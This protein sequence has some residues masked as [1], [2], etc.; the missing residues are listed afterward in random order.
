M[1]EAAEGFGWKELRY[2][3]KLPVLALWGLSEV[4]ISHS[5][6]LLPCN[7]QPLSHVNQHCWCLWSCCKFFDI[8]CFFPKFESFRQVNLWE[9]LLVILCAS[10]GGK[11]LKMWLS[12]VL[13]VKQQHK[14]HWETILI[15]KGKIHYQYFHLKTLLFL[16]LIPYKTLV[17]FLNQFLCF[18]LRSK[19]WQV[20]LHIFI[21]MR[22][23]L[24][25]ILSIKT[26]FK[27]C[28]VCK[29]YFSGQNRVPS[30]HIPLNG[31]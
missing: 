5:A 30:Y 21:L 23:S 8:R 4:N 19:V 18:W 11:E 13:K 29:A 22:L 2:L 16:D 10:S 9:C 24:V 14:Q 7:L 15:Q 20:F 3:W 26:V 27:N 25:F 12:T 6:Q 17:Y 28:K 1:K 31:N